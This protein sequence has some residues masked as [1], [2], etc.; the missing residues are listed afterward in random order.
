MRRAVLCYGKSDPPWSSA[1]NLTVA[2]GSPFHHAPWVPIHVSICQS[3]GIDF[4]TGPCKGQFVP[5][6][7]SVPTGCL[8][9]PLRK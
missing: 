4:W 6:N 2:H 7:A 3:P 9:P 8:A 1:S 5:V